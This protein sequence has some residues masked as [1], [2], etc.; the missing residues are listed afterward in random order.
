MRE[1]GDLETVRLVIQRASDQDVYGPESRIGFPS[2]KDPWHVA[3][4]NSSY[5][6][7]KYAHWA[8]NRSVQIHQESIETLE[9]TDARAVQISHPVHLGIGV[10]NTIEH[11]EIVDKQLEFLEK[12][13]S[14]LEERAS[15]ETESCYDD[16][17]REGMNFARTIIPRTRLFAHTYLW[18]QWALEGIRQADQFRG[19]L[20]NEH[21]LNQFSEN[22]F[23]YIAH[24]PIIVATTACTTMIE[25]VGATYINSYVEGSYWD[26]DETSAKAVLDEIEA[27][28]INDAE[29]TTSKIRNWV[30]PSRDNLSHYVIKRSE[31]IDTSDFEKFYTG[32]IETIQL[33]HSLLNDLLFPQIDEFQSSLDTSIRE[34]ME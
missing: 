16:L 26:K 2:A 29:L 10:K 34:I 11:V 3:I 32:I 23:P 17:A 5:G 14:I 33:M 30:I 6:L 18:I 8:A 28:Y 4:V 22:A 15:F 27:E 1:F 24:P 7:S 31:V 19:L 21:Q 13:F 20:R 25:E 9:N 12:K